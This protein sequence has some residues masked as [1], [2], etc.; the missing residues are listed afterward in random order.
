MQDVTGAYVF[1]FFD[2]L[3]QE[4]KLSKEVVIATA[5]ASLQKGLNLSN[6][7]SIDIV[8]FG[9]NASRSERGLEIIRDG[10]ESIANFLKH[11]D[12]SLFG[13]SFSEALAFGMPYD[14][15]FNKKKEQENLRLKPME[16][17]KSYQTRMFDIDPNTKYK[18]LEGDVKVIL[19]E[20]SMKVTDNFGTTEIKWTKAETRGNSVC[21]DDTHGVQWIIGKQRITRYN[22]D[23]PEKA[24]HFLRKPDNNENN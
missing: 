16:Y 23:A 4:R 14:E 11:K 21:F 1:G 8:D 3:G 20:Q 7:D 22:A 19:T 17:G 2:Y 15:D 24:L 6:E 18:Q 10:A 9:V 5:K 12:I 13:R